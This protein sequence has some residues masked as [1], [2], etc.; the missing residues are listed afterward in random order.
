MLYEIKKG[1]ESLLHPGVNANVF[2][3]IKNAIPYYLSP[4][5]DV[6]SPLTIYWSINSICNLKCKMCDIGMKNTEGTFYKNLGIDKSSHEIDI[7]V[8]KKVV[9]EVSK[10]KPF[11]VINSTEPLLYKPIIE[12]IKYCSKKK[13]Q[14]AITTN[15]FLLPQ[16]AQELAKAGLKRL[17]VSIDGPSKI[18]NK[19]RG[20]NNSFEKAIE[21]IKKFA[22]YSKKNNMKSEIYISYV[23]SNLNY[24]YL[25]ELAKFA[26]TLPISQINF[27]YLWFINPE[28][29]EEQNKKF[30]KKFSVSTSCY[31]KAINP[32]DV[33]T[34][35]LFNQ[36]EKLKNN[37]KITFLPN[38]T[39]KEI[40]KYY[41]KPNNFMK[42]NAKCLASWFI[43]QILANGNVI[44]YTRC[45]NNSF[46]NIYKS[47]FNSIWNGKEMKNWRNF[48]K[49][50]KKMPMCKRCDLVY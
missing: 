36:K 39:E 35:I 25:V 40:F 4:K 24:K 3:L 18:H 10:N 31:N 17:N 43:I 37:K 13:L 50:H 5:M 7:N 34:K 19:I 12:A 20:V 38:F 45:H 22:Y 49:K 6:P 23:I 27:T 15:G 28:C 44:P 32:F 21:G 16:K 11:M 42:E 8:F 48:I 9:D 33:D 46:G 47:K 14:T 2:K 26:E 1:F 41:H 30:G 29:A